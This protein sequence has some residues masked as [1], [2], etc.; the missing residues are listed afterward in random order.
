MYYIVL[1]SIHGYQISDETIQD[2]VVY[3]PLNKL[4]NIVIVNGIVSNLSAQVPIPSCDALGNA[5]S[6]SDFRSIFICQVLFKLFE[7][8]ILDRFSTSLVS[9]DNQFGLK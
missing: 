3:C 1:T 7:H 6:V 9:S 5:I 8:C 4:F 2:L